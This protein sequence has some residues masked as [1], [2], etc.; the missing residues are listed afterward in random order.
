[1]RTSRSL[2]RLT[3][4]GVAAP[5]GAQ[6]IAIDIHGNQSVST[7]WLEPSDKRVTIQT[8]VPGSSNL[9]EQ[10]M[11]NGLLYVS[12]RSTHVP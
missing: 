2:T 8:E 11:V 5:G 6:Q 12:V 3:G 1:V 9:A 10:V 4:L 7:T